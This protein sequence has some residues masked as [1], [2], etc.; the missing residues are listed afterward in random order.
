MESTQ[1]IEIR[2][3]HGRTWYNSE[4]MPKKLL[5]SVEH[6]AVYRAIELNKYELL[7]ITTYCI[8]DFDCKGFPDPFENGDTAEVRR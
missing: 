6:H 3:K 8:L 4:R 5:F 7:L 1:E 2:Q